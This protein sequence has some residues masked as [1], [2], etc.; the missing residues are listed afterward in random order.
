[1]LSS[2]LMHMG[3]DSCN[4]TSNLCVFFG[5]HCLVNFL[6]IKGLTSACKCF[7]KG[8]LLCW[9]IYECDQCFLSSQ[10]LSVLSTTHLSIDILITDIIVIFP[11]L[12][13]KITAWYWS[14]FQSQITFEHKTLID[15][16]KL[17]FLLKTAFIWTNKK[18]S[19]W[20]FE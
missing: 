1:M 10:V 12:Y 13:P 3:T 18:Y 15:I 6:T 16:Q 20:F 9:K 2:S 7:G 17:L 8:L 11:A 4:V 19:L 14:E 5:N